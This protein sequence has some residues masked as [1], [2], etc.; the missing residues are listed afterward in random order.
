M[1]RIERFFKSIY[2]SASSVKGRRPRETEGEGR[3]RRK[4]YGID[5][6]SDWHKL[7]RQSRT[8]Y[9]YISNSHRHTKASPSPGRKPA[10]A[11]APVSESKPFKQEEGSPVTRPRNFFTRRWIVT[12]IVELGIHV[13]HASS[14]VRYYWC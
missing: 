6:E 8:I 11:S 12:R 3:K 10:G 5:Q 7:Y 9:I 13:N 2:R 14:S 4:Q 1:G